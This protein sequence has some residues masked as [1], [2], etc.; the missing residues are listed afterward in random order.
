MSKR[1]EKILRAGM[2][3]YLAILFLVFVPTHHHKDYK[4]HDDCFVCT[5][6]HRPAQVIAAFALPIVTVFF[7]TKLVLPS[8]IL[9]CQ[10]PSSLQS[11][12]PPYS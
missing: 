3:I 7:I 9:I 10:T 4:E 8:T 5:I 11:R 1:A 6:T 2:V 12:A